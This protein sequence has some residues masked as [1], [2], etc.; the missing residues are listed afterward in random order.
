MLS[1]ACLNNRTES[2]RTP[3]L[4]L[5]VPALVDLDHGFSVRNN[6]S[7]QAAARRS[8]SMYLTDMIRPTASRLQATGSGFSGAGESRRR[9]ARGW[10][11]ELQHGRGSSRVAQCSA[12]L[13][14][15]TRY[16]CSGGCEALPVEAHAVRDPRFVPSE[17]TADAHLSPSK[18]IASMHGMSGNESQPFTVSRIAGARSPCRSRLAEGSHRI[19]A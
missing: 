7:S 13:P 15:A 19:L 4:R 8:F 1:A 11:S 16:H 12:S 3:R 10:I 18:T 9:A 2:P 14:S 17:R 5:D 6:S